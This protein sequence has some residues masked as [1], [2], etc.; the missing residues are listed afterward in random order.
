MRR[1]LTSLLIAIA[2]SA[3]LLP[4]IGNARGH[5][6]SHSTGPYY[7]G[8]HHTESHGGHYVGGQGSSH[9]G[10]HYVNPRTGNHYGHHKP[11]NQIAEGKARLCAEW[12]SR[13]CRLPDIG[14]T[15]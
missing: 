1:R 7:G 13:N 6:S 9:K 14:S 12:L 2:A 15:N 3:L 11:P 4:T 8:G 10:G 5:S